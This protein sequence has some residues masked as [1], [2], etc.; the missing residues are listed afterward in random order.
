M[1]YTFPAQTRS[2]YPDRYPPGAPV[3]AVRADG[4]SVL[5]ADADGKTRWYIDCVNGM[6]SVL[7][8]HAHPGVNDAVEAQLQRGVAFPLGSEL[9]EIVAQ[10]LC[11]MLTW[12]G[13]EAVR[14]GKNG[15]DVTSAA[16]KLARAA[17]GR[18]MV[19]K[20]AY[21]GHHP[22]ASNLAPMNAGLLKDELF[23]SRIVPH[24]DCAALRHEFGMN[25]IAALVFEI[26][27]SGAP[28]LPTPEYL[29]LARKLCDETGAL[30]ILDEVVTGF[31]M[32][33][34]GAAEVYDLRPD[35]AC[36]GKAL[37]NGFPLSALV[38]PWDLM[39]RL[40][41]DVFF[42]TTHGG[43]AASLAAALVTLEAVA[44]RHVPRALAELGARI[45]EIVPTVGYDARPFFRFAEPD[46]RERFLSHLLAC[47]VLCQGY[48]NLS[49]ATAVEPRARQML[50]SAI[51]EAAAL[52]EVALVHPVAE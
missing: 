50:L 21:H 15:A 49:E 28:E 20:N 40:D 18:S 32:A 17:T 14:F 5:C 25:E 34:G 37:A 51:A 39:G 45:R 10:R 1:S 23:L 47:G 8:G 33:S 26:V 4:A 31:R 44:T 27:P 7:L 38:G 30:L 13:A 36:Y 16:V 9:D 2:K 48:V 19:L 29:Q 41:R 3:R 22:W 52:D 12:P 24:N 46:A 43:E 42:S 6:G 35:L 11:S